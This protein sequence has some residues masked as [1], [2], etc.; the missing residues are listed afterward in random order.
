MH[1]IQNN[2]IF[3]KKIQNFSYKI[4]SYTPS[5]NNAMIENKT[6][7]VENLIQENER[8]KQIIA[9]LQKQ[10]PQKKYGLVW[11]ETLEQENK[12]NFYLE[13]LKD[14]W[15]PTS[16][17]SPE[18]WLLEGDNLQALR[19]LSHTHEQKIDLIYI[20][21]PYNTGNRDFKYK[22]RFS[23]AD[24]AYKHSQWISFMNK[25]LRLAKDLLH[26]RGAIF[27]SIDDTELGQ[28]KL[29]CNEIFGE[30]NF[31][32]NF[33][34]KC[35]SGSGHDSGKIAVEFDY[36]LCYAKDITLQ[37]FNKKLVHAAT[38]QKYRY[39][40]EFEAYRGKYYLRDLDYKGNYSPTLDYMIQAPDGTEIWPGGKLGKPNT[41][42]WSREKFEWGLEHNFIVFK[43]TLK[44]W[45]V[46]IKQY[47]FV[48]N[49]DR[50]RERQIPHRAILEFSN[51]KGSNE[52]KDILH[53]N[54]FTYPK[55]IDLIKF[56][57]NLLP[58]K[59]L[60]ILDFFAGSGT[61]GHA[62][63]HLNQQSG[64]SHRFILCTNN[65]SQICEKVCYERLK[66]IIEGYTTRNGK[67]VEGTGEGL[68]YWKI[69]ELK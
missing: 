62:V 29:L 44:K 31:V 37:N 36:M 54:T 69:Q 32:A 64:T 42:R 65:E 66:R 45:K 9:V 4:A 68:K 60:T 13:E 49:R 52:L 56:V 25:R 50:K 58:G 53:E 40:D 18:H 41:W 7:S 16:T 61:T 57:I 30:K 23:D 28:T 8:L 34:R 15:L 10:A 3:Y 59:Q 19:L 2:I 67:S 14:K 43:K 27:I 6:V 1:Y 5:S 33:I 48:D 39:S 47:Q 63:L 20:D 11:E 17:Q 26:E 21:P 55:P 12:E 22:D 46:Y 51:A 35:K 24:A 38:D